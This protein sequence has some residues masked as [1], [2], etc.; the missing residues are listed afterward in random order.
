MAHR[1]RPAQ[2]FF[3][4]HLEIKW[5]RAGAQGEARCPFHEDRRASLSVNRDNGL[6]F[7]HADDF[8]GTA[9]EFAERLGVEAPAN[10]RHWQSAPMT[11]AMK[12]VRCSIR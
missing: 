3:E 4:Q 2:L 8:G 12:T 5:R 11:T 1:A 9:R 7:C 6:W 10:N